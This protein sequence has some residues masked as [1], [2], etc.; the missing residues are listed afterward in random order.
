M[1][2]LRTVWII[3]RHYKTDDKMMHLLTLISNE[4][5]DKVENQINIKELYTLTED[6]SSYEEQLN[7][8]LN[9][10]KLGLKILKNWIHLWKTTRQKIEEEGLDRWDFA[11]PAISTRIDH[12]VTVLKDL[13]KNTEILK[14]FLVF[15][16]PDLKAVTGNSEGIDVLI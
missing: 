7:V 2:G 16:G 1:N 8:S 3:S 5:A 10:I 6:N 15:L 9:N 14:K 13:E 11:V 4:I 12:M